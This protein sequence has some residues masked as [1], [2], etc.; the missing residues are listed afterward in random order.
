MTI[1]ILLT[2]I[3]KDLKLY[4]KNRFFAFI[5]LLGLVFFIGIYFLLPDIVN[6]TMELAVVSPL[7]FSAT[8]AELEEGG[9]VLRIMADEDDLRAAVESDDV[10]VGI[11]FPEDLAQMLM[12]GETP[13]VT[14]YFSAAMPPETQDFY[15]ILVQEWVAE[16]IGEPLNVDASEEVIGLDRGGDQIPARD[17]MLPLFAVL[18]LMLETLGLGSLIA[19]EAAAGTLQALL[20]TPLRIAGLFISKGV[21]GVLLA[22]SQAA[23]FT[24][25]T[26]GLQEQPLLILTALLLGSMLVT[27]V[28]FLL[29]SVA[30]DMMSVMA[31]GILA[32]LV[33]VI[34][35]MNILLPGLTTGWEKII[36]SYYLADSVYRAANAQAGWAELGGEL[37]ILAAWTAGILAIGVL[38]LR[39]RMR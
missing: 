38:V 13:E 9:V 15:P 18:I 39:R 32:L 12:A 37:G 22:F 17:R 5:T 14:I 30:K 11:V 3:V 35:A 16:V 25:V 2:M 4:F 24:L 20:V 21:V 36:P 28:A 34:P 10:P 7:D 6:E 33:L 31:W 8:Q 19:S 26:G 1:P 29:A 23:I 27:G